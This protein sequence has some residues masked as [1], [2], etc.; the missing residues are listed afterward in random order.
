MAAIKHD[1]HL[2]KPL[3]YVD[4]LTDYGFKLLFGD[5]ELLMGFLN[6][7]FE[8]DGKVVTSVRYLSKEIVSVTRRGRT[9][10]YDLLCKINGSEDVIIEMQYRSQDTFVERSFYYMAQSIMHQ[11]DSKKNWNYKMYPVYG[12][13]LMNFHLPVKD[14]P[15]KVVNE[16]VP[17]FKG[18]D[19]V[20]TNKFRMFF[21]DLLNFEKTDESELETLFDWWIFSIKNMGRISYRPNVVKPLERLYSRAEV[22]AMNPRQYREYER[23]LKA[24]RDAYSIALTE[25]NERK[26]IREEARTEGLA[27]GREVGLAEGRAEGR[28]EGEKEGA[29]NANIATARSMKA[30]GMSVDVIAKYTGLTPD[31]IDNL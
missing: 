15:K 25:R 22:A 4:I 11:G 24:T 16:V 30:D 7:L 18:T 27:E 8:D 29:K 17:V 31:E 19:T 3:K 1:S 5:K 21:I 28:V 26:R 6:A 14:A 2:Y 9:I 23:S 10:Y 13:F 20:L 12:I